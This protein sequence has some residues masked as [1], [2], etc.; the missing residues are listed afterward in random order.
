MPCC[1]CW[2]V[3]RGADGSKIGSVRRRRA[4]VQAAGQQRLQEVRMMMASS[5]GEGDDGTM[6]GPQRLQETLERAARGGDRRAL[7]G[8]FASGGAPTAAALRAS[9]ADAVIRHRVGG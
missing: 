1:G 9:T 7:P 2:A 6:G 5:R 4:A 3:A 8:L